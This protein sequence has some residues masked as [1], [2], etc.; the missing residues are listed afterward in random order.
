M[1]KK[2]KPTLVGFEPT[3]SKSNGLAIH[4]LDHSAT[5]SRGKMVPESGCPMCYKRCFTNMFT[6]SKKKDASGSEK[7][8]R[9]QLEVMIV[10]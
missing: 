9:V 8:F 3:R 1:L 7:R 6:F 10:C 4:R 2:A 5:M